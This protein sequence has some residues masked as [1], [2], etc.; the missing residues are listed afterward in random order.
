MKLIWQYLRKYKLEC[1]IAP[2]FKLLEACFD[3]CVPLVVAS[4]VD[5]GI[6]AGNVGYIWRM[7][8]L[9]ILLS[10]VGLS[11]TLVAQYFSAR[12]AVGSAKALRHDLFAHLQKFSH[13]QT[14]SLGVP[15][16][17]TRMTSDTN[18]IQT[19]INLTLRLLLRS[20]VIVFGA[21]IMAFCVKPS[22]AW[23][24]V[25]VIPLLSVVV[26]T[27]ILAGI[28]LYKRIQSRLDGVTAKTRE[29]LRGVRA[30]RAF[31][32]QEREID[33]FGK[34]NRAQTALQNFTG[35]I[36]ALMNPLTFILVNGGIVALVWFG[37]RQFGLPD[38]V[39]QGELI[40]LVSY[41]SQ[42]LVELV[43]LANTIITVTKAVA[44][45]SR[46]QSVMDIPAGM[47]ESTPAPDKADGSSVCFENVT[48][49]YRGAGAPSLQ[50]VS[51]SVKPG[52][53]VGI[54][55]GTGSGKSS[56]VGLIPRFY[57]ATEGHVFVD[58]KDVKGFDPVILRDTVV[59]VPQ[60]AVLVSG[61][62]R[63]NLLWGNENATDQQLWEALEAAQ[64][65]DFVQQKPEGLDAPVS[66]NGTN[67]S[68]GQRQRLTIARALVAKS[69]ILILDDSASALDFATDAALR[70]A[71]KALPHKPTVF[72]V[73][74]RTASIA[75]ADLI[76]VLEDGCV[77]G[78]GTHESLLESCEVYREIYDSQFK[79][80]QGA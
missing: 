54:I 9:L 2:L 63:S 76:L 32:L 5:G 60:K 43:K 58:G 77:V 74:Q 46:I 17:I 35:R 27:V 39:T 25:A 64:A 48:L 7:F 14:D 69:P 33:E 78:Q 70:H 6:E 47:P 26:F 44:C 68:G 22:L 71:I 52:T 62:I 10:V 30:V 4:I 53:T 3:L 45:G 66:Q 13:E 41:M 19:G 18:Q 42:I 1:V 67:F 29:T 31:G 16:M 34:V 49:T 11:C 59:T 20:P 79:G 65:K 21:M 50:D 37:S 51:F 28:P 55:G 23:I 15:A 36:T 40:A 75:H 56:L 38:G 61:T 8:G 57:D 24:F 73:S 72:I 80:G 12:A